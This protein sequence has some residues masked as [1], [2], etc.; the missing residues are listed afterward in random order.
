M[1]TPAAQAGHEHQGR[2]A[3]SFPSRPDAATLS[4]LQSATANDDAALDDEAYW[5]KICERATD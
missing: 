4:A 3:Q 2:H 5:S 1:T